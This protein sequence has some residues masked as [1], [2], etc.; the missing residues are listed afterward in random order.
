M[1]TNIKSEC[2]APFLKYPHLARQIIFFEKSSHFCQKK[3]SFDIEYSC[4]III[5]I[6]H[7]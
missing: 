5:N 2:D 6:K 4:H 7:E 1:L 3:K